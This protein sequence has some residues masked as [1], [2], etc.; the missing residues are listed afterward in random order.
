LLAEE[1]DGARLQEAQ[2]NIKPKAQARN[3]FIEIEPSADSDGRKSPTE[4][5]RMQ[6]DECWASEAPAG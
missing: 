5:S 3:F 6:H 4:Q 1:E 2:H